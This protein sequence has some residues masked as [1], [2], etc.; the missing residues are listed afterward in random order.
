M[1]CIQTFSHVQQDNEQGHPNRKIALNLSDVHSVVNSIDQFL[2]ATDSNDRDRLWSL[3]IEA[4]FKSFTTYFQ[5]IKQICSLN[6]LTSIDD[7]LNGYYQDVLTNQITVA[8]SLTGF[9]LF[10]DYQPDEHRFKNYHP[11]FDVQLT[12]CTHFDLVLL[13]MKVQIVLAQLN[14][15]YFMGTNTLIGAMRHHDIVPWHNFVEFMLPDS[16]KKILFKQL[17][18]KFQFD[19]REINVVRIDRE[20]QESIYHLSQAKHSHVLIELKFYQ[21]TER[22]IFGPWIDTKTSMI[23]DRIEKS[24]I[25]PVNLRPFGPLLLPTIRNSYSLI[26][27]TDISMCYS[28]STSTNNDKHRN[29]TCQQLEHLYTFVRSERSWRHGFCE[30]TVKTNRRPYR[31]LSY[32]RYTCRENG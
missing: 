19:I 5:R 12:S 30:E 22:E 23:N 27:S 16:C 8:R 18:L 4:W 29:V 9:G 31:I 1:L 24:E 25:F 26:S 28:T 20:R 32:F 2:D 17:I 11:F 3:L 21:E 14:I 7:Y 15:E 13:V 6:Q 10:I